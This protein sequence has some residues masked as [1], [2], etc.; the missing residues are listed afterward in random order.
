[1]D[2]AESTNDVIDFGDATDTIDFGDAEIEL[3]DTTG[4]LVE[5]N[6][7]EIDFGIEAVDDKDTAIECQAAGQ[8]KGI[9]YFRQCQFSFPFIL[10]NYVF[11]Q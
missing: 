1:M 2:T 10:I 8:E 11:V 5:D 4:I 3:V 6:G 7:A 9:R